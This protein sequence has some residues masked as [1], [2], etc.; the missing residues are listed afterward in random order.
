MMECEVSDDGDGDG[1]KH[2][3]DNNLFYARWKY[4]TVTT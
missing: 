1:A 2:D 3:Y 4:L